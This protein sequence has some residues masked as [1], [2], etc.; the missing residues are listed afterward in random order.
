VPTLAAVADGD[1]QDYAQIPLEDV[2]SDASPSTVTKP[3]VFSRAFGVGPFLKELK[4]QRTRF[5]FLAYFTGAGLSVFLYVSQIAIKLACIQFLPSILVVPVPM[6]FLFLLVQIDT[7]W[8]HTVLTY[9]SSK[10]IWERIPPFKTTFCTVGP[11]FALLLAAKVLL[12]FI[13]HGVEGFR[14]REPGSSFLEAVVA[15]VP[16]DVVLEFLIVTPVRIV[17]VRIQA[18]LLPADEKTIIPLDE[19]LRRDGKGEQSGAIGIK[20][21]WRTFGRNTWRRYFVIYLQVLLLVM[22]GGGV[23]SVLAFLMTSNIIFTVSEIIRRITHH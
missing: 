9:P 17:L 1:S 22:I 6:L 20:D 19:A 14:I 5:R 3:R 11:V 15:R 7:L 10:S 2:E 8:T 4:S 23:V 18:S 13:V 21:A 16:M 12:G